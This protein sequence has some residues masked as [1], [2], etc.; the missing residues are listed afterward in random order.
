MV[1]ISLIHAFALITFL[2][3]LLLLKEEKKT[4]MGTGSGHVEEK[5]T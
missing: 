1:S 3:L 2:L 4:I 5:S